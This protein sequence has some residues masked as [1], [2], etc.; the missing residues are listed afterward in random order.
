VPY[1]RRHQFVSEFNWDLPFGK[2]RRWTQLPQLLQV[3]AGNWITTGIFQAASGNY[4]TPCYSGFDASGTGV[5]SGRPDRFAHSRLLPSYPPD[6]ARCTHRSLRQR[7]DWHLIGP[8]RWQYDMSLVKYVPVTEQ[9]RINFFVLGTN[10]FNH[11][12]LGNPSLDI[13]APLVVGQINGIHTDGNAGGIGMRQL[14]LIEI[15]RQK[16]PAEIMNRGHVSL[17]VNRQDHGAKPARLTRVEQEHLPL[18]P[19]R[20][21]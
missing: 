21:R 13:T 9:I 15:E 1:I 10:I 20:R 12:N 18:A 17:R 14:R 6:G 2:G 19:W 4:L 11:P 5:I 16:V 8:G 7:R 3:I